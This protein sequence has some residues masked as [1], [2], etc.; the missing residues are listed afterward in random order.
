M[1]IKT[2]LEQSGDQSGSA[3]TPSPK[4]FIKFDAL[5]FPSFSR[6]ERIAN[7]GNRTARNRS[8]E[9]IDGEINSLMG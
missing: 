4:D 3:T 6:D 5:Q 1:S 7:Q 8:K 2:F 9:R